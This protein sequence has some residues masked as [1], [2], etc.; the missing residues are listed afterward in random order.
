MTAERNVS[1]KVT[2]GSKPPSLLSEEEKACGP[3]R[4]K[5]WKLILFDSLIHFKHGP[6]NERLK[7]F[8]FAAEYIQLRRVKDTEVGC[9]WMKWQEVEQE[10][11]TFISPMG[12][13]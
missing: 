2:D 12:V 5:V 11:L 8:T 9:L 4:L 7:D 1:R 3:G 10:K 13:R 6:Q